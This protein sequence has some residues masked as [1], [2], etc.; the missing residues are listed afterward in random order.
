MRQCFHFQDLG[1]LICSLI[2]EVEK[3]VQ[4]IRVVNEEDADNSDD[5]EE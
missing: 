1:L 2:P 5:P 4:G 3:N